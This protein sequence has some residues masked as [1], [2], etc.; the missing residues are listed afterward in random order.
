MVRCFDDENVIHVD[1]SVDPLRDIEVISLELAL[2][3]LDSVERRYQKVAKDKKA[4]PEEKSALE[5][6]LPVLEEGQAARLVD[7]SD[8]EEKAVRSLGLLTR[9]PVCPPSFPSSSYK[10]PLFS[11]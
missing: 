9:K 2:A 8:E 1:G 11:F 4:A 10:Y 6:L 3:D 7:M 5:K